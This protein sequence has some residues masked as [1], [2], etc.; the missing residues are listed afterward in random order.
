MERLLEL[1][2]DEKIANTLATLV[3]GHDTTA[4]TMQFTLMELARNKPVQRRV[5]SECVHI[6]DE[7]ERDGRSLSYSDLPRFELLTKCIC[8]T[9]RMWNVAGIVFPRVT[10]FEDKIL[11]SDG[12]TMV[13]IPKGTKFTFWYYGQH[14]SQEL[15]GSDAMTWNPDREWRPHELQKSE[16]PNDSLWSTAR[17]P[18]SERFH[19]FSVPTRDC[20]GKGFAMSE[21]RILLSRVLLNFEINIPAGSELESVKPEA[22][23]VVYANW[24]RN[25]GGPTQPHSLVLKITPVAS[26]SA[27]I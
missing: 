22:G 9:L 16:V 21:M 3:A 23:N 13:N 27:K 24:T 26:A 1:E 5:R 25:I 4:Y 20:M 6:L 8:E 17:T 19:P 18:L 10:S 11:S 15:W 7:I 2:Q 14:H 12:T